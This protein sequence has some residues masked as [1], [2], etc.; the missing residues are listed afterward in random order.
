MLIIEFVD[1]SKMT[2]GKDFQ[3]W[4][5]IPKDKMIA[6]VLITAGG[7]LVKA[8]RGYDKYCMEYEAVKKAKCSTN[9]NGDIDLIGIGK[10]QVIAQHL[11]CIK[12]SGQHKKRVSRWIYDELDKLEKALD[13][14]D[15]A[16]ARALISERKRLMKKL[17]DICK[18]ME[19][20]EVVT[21]TIGLTAVFSSRKQMTT[22]KDRFRPGL[23][24]DNSK[25]WFEGIR[26]SLEGNHVNKNIDNSK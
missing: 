15:R 10:A 12:Y 3:N 5:E 4:D 22:A 6:A 16:V 17:D 25:E 1:G 13:G 19:E 7:Q 21:Y 18:G 20:R 26:P 9:T 23:P 11:Q 2:E 24:D 14:A 8:I